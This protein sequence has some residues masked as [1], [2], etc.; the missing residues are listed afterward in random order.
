MC[1]DQKGPYC[2]SIAQR[3][4]TKQDE[5]KSN[6]LMNKENM[7]SCSSK[8]AEQKIASGLM[9]LLGFL[10]F[11]FTLLFFLF[12]FFNKTKQI[13]KQKTKRKK[14]KKQTNKAKT[15]STG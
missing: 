2:V 10:S 4:G 8:P 9:L 7:N 5:I 15:L 12:S 11:F 1:G 14:K 3:T 6:F 13:T